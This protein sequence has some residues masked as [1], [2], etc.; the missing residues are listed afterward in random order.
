[1]EPRK[2]Q[3]QNTENQEMISIL[4]AV[5]SLSNLT[6]YQS[7][8]WSVETSRREGMIW[9]D[10]CPTL[11]KY[12]SLGALQISEAAW[13]DA[14]EHDPSIGGTWHDCASLEYSLK[15]QTAYLDRY[16]NERRL[17]RKPTDYDR[18]RIWVGG[19]NGYK[20]ESSKPYGKKI[21]E[22]I[23]AETEG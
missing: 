17:G 8:T 20:R 7:A 23:K 16:C 9:G 14:I 5:L 4:S 11:G 15:I 2:I 21:L 19:P 18:A 10:W 1:M 3:I 22:Q 12:R 6:P 13:Y